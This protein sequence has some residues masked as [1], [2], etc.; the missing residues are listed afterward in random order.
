MY[1]TL[2]DS[3]RL[4]DLREAGHGLR[5]RVISVLSRLLVARRVGWISF[6]PGIIRR[7]ARG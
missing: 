6:T 7:E 5:H 1:D 2:G 4:G 3:R